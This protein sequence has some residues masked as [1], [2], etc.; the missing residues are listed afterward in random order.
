MKQVEEY[1]NKVYRNA[2]GNKD[3]I[4]DLK[5]E[6][7]SHLLE[8]V[9]EL[10]SE[11]KNEDE[12]VDIAIERFGKEN[13]LRSLINQVFQTQKKFG[14]RLLYAGLGIFVLSFIIFIITIIPVSDIH[15]EQT[16]IVND[17]FEII[18]TDG[19]L[20][21]ANKIEIEGILE[22]ANFSVGTVVVKNYL[23]GNEVVYEYT[24]YDNPLMSK[25]YSSY[26]TGSEMHSVFI[27]SKDYSFLGLLAL[28]VGGTTFVL[29]AM[30]W[31]IIKA[32]NKQKTKL[33]N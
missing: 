13:E 28:L 21:E 12:A 14:K 33:F 31:S 3:E 18:P 32:Y 25:L 9:H 4:Q 11:G 16:A 19:Q 8:S 27:D 1:V 20:S 23:N 15:K 26:F 10:I 22:D 6:M 2:K 24:T 5:S 17:I 7:K 29:F 30:L